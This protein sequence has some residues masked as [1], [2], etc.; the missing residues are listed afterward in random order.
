MSKVELRK[1]LFIV[2]SGERFSSGMIMQNIKSGKLKTSL[3][4]L[5]DD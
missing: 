5:L 3:E 1:Y 4:M 2:F